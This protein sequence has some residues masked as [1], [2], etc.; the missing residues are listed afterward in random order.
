VTSPAGIQATFESWARANSTALDDAALLESVADAR[1]V[2]VGEPGHGAHE[3]LAFRN[4][5]VR[6]L[7]EAGLLGAVAIESGVL[8][9][10]ALNDYVRHGGTDPESLVRAHVTW[11]F[12]QMSDNVDLIRMLRA[13]NAQCK[14]SDK[15]AFFGFDIPGGDERSDLTLG[16]LAPLTVAKYIRAQEGASADGLATELEAFAGALQRPLVK[17]L[18]EP[19]RERVRRLLDAAEDSLSQRRVDAHAGGWDDDGTWAGLAARMSRALFEMLLRW[20]DLPAGAMSLPDKDI[21]AM[22]DAS[23]W[24]DR[25][26]ADNIEWLLGMVGGR[27]V[28]MFAA[29]G[30]V[31]G[32]RHRGGLWVGHEDRGLPAGFHLRASLGPSY[33]VVLTCSSATLPGKE[34][35]VP[36][37]LDNLLADG[38]G[39]ARMIDL[40]TAPDSAWLDTVQSIGT[41]SIYPQAFEP[42]RAF[43]I[44]VHFPTLTAAPRTTP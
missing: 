8:E 26:M 18:R 42:R 37:S 14:D 23:A 2:A 20:P 30:H 33:R 29:N 44:L 31:I 22:L 4:R 1:L 15:V 36:R 16:G 19:D 3:P 27:C 6:L 10:R 41:N 12:G 17:L 34:S 25:A 40:R 28:L 9:S 32:D 35:D 39:A 38:T 24:R 13:H 21:P 43:D 11:N 7:L 5:L